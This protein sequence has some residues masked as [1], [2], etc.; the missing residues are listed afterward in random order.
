MR[1]VMRLLLRSG[2]VGR[3]GLESEGAGTWSLESILGS[4]SINFFWED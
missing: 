4:S 3:V 1:L 2:L